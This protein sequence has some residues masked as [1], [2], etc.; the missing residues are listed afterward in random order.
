MKMSRIIFNHL[1]QLSTYDDVAHS[2][3]LSHFDRMMD[4]KIADRRFEYIWFKMKDL[5]GSD[6]SIAMLNSFQAYMVMNDLTAM[7]RRLATIIMFSAYMAK[8]LNDEHETKTFI[9][10]AM[11]IFL[12]NY[13]HWMD[14][15]GG[16][17]SGYMSWYNQSVILAKYRIMHPIQKQTIYMRLRTLF[18]WVLSWSPIQIHLH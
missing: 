7:W 1:S 17:K 13:S 5:H 8:R 18:W 16:W 12:G 6:L 14:V 2:E 15:N 11:N 4:K 9:L 10:P 3:L